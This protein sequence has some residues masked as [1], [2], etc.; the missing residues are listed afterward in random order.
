MMNTIQKV[1][2]KVVSS[3]A[4]DLRYNTLTNTVGIG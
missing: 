2:H 4:N 3:I 1:A